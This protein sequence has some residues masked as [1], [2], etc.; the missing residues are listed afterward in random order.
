M[1]AEPAVPM[2][3]GL[4]GAAFALRA[5]AQ[6]PGRSDAWESGFNHPTNPR[7][8]A[9]GA[10]SRWHSLR[11]FCPVFAAWNTLKRNWLLRHSGRC[12]R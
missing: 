9:G 5:G 3:L 11:I 7:W 6:P 4:V 8:P 1:D 10:I 12:V 2:R